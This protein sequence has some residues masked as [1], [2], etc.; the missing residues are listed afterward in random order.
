MI[1]DSRVRA[2]SG[3]AVYMSAV[4]EQVADNELVQSLGA[5]NGRFI[6][7]AEFGVSKIQLDLV[8]GAGAYR[9]YRATAREHWVLDPNSH[10]DQRISVTL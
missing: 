1:F 3:Q 4:A 8:R 2:G 6:N 7:P 5:Y 10:P 9:L